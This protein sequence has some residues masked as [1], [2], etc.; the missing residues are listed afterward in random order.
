MFLCLLPGYNFVSVMTRTVPTQ[1][2]CRQKVL[3][4]MVGVLLG[5]VLPF[6]CTSNLGSTPAAGQC[7]GLISTAA[8]TDV[9]PTQPDVQALGLILSLGRAGKL[10]NVFKSL[11]ISLCGR[12]L[13]QISWVT[14]P[15]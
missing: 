3:G 12:K 7:L 15:G 8:R 6:G 1:G 4:V 14:F 10:K 2:P 5:K 11:Q 9:D 13:C